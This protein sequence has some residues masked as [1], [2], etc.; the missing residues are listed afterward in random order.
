M[1]GWVSLL[2]AG[3]HPARVERM[4]LLVPGGVVP[5]NWVN[6]LPTVIPDD[7]ASYAV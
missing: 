1:T 3:T 4:A 5:V 6:V 7:R 2:F